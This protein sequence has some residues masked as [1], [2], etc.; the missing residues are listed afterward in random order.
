MLLE[1]EENDR[2]L[3]AAPGTG[4]LSE[5]AHKRCP[6]DSD[7]KSLCPGPGPG[8]PR[9]TRPHS[10]RLTEDTR[11]GRRDLRVAGARARAR[12]ITM[13]GNLN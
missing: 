13:G 2:D 12:A 3:D 4:S 10:L 9:L 7:G 11:A 6:A 8:P 5:C 1:C